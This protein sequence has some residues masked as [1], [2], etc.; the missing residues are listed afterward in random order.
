[1]AVVTPN[2]RP[3]S[4]SR[5]PRDQGVKGWHGRV[6]VVTHQSRGS[7]AAAGAPRAYIKRQRVAVLAQHSWLSSCRRRLKGLT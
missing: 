2:S 7:A 5:G 3:N 1:M 6:A 4:C